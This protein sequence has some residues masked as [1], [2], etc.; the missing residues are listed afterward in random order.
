MKSGS[1]GNKRG[2]LDP[3]WVGGLFEQLGITAHFCTP[4]SPWAKGSVES[5]GDTTHEDFCRRFTSF[6]GGSP[7]RRPD[8]ADKWAKEHV[9]EL[10]TIAEVEEAFGQFVQ[11]HIE[12]PSEAPGIAPLSPRQKFESTRIAQRTIP[13]RFWTS[14]S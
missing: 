6:C 8:G 10:P 1:F 4:Y 3:E 13:P 2:W 9:A 7:E 14:C 11:A 12:R 5:F